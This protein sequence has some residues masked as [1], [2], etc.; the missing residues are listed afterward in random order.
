MGILE[1]RKVKPSSVLFSPPP[2]TGAHAHLC[3]AEHLE[4]ICV[5]RFD[6]F[7]V[8]GE[9]LLLN[10]AQVQWVGHLLVILTVPGGAHTHTDTKSE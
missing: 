3:I 1:G 8:A 4:H 10:G 2:L 5:K 9:D 7:V 6:G